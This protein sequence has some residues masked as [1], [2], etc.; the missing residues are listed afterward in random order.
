MKWWTKISLG[1]WRRT[2]LHGMQ[3][4]QVR[5]IH[6][7]L[8]MCLIIYSVGTVLKYTTLPS[9]HVLLPSLPEPIPCMS[10]GANL[11]TCAHLSW[12]KAGGQLA[13][14]RQHIHASIR[15]YQATLH[16][17]G[18]P[19]QEEAYLQIRNSKLAILVY[20]ELPF[21][22][23]SVAGVLYKGDFHRYQFLSHN[24]SATPAVSL[25]HRTLLTDQPTEQLQMDTQTGRCCVLDSHSL[26]H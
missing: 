8:S 4:V 14:W 9:L 19:K 2:L 17:V 10:S 11:T 7:V 3:R 1:R 16:H 15:G 18:R 21:G 26:R 22:T 24:L 25:E 23:A 12:W 13:T 20:Q 6:T 5:A